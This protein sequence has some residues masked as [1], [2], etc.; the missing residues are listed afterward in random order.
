MWRLRDELRAIRKATR[1]PKEVSRKNAVDK[2][3]NA[4][5]ELCK[6]HT[7]DNHMRARIQGLAHYGAI[8]ACCGESRYEFL[9]FDHKNN[10]GAAHRR[11][12]RGAA[13]IAQWLKKN[14]YPDGF[15]VL[16]MNCNWAKGRYGECPHERELKQDVGQII[17]PN[18]WEKYT[19][20][21]R[22]M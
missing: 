22:A 18:A 16:C 12:D 19:R 8:C 10:D 6:A 5:S 15:Q 14:D 20:G 1:P 17:E 7:A 11:S 13:R 9:T 3:R 4:N 2:Y 21:I